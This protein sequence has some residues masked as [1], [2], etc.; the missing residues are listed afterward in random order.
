MR[1]ASREEFAEAYTQYPLPREVY[2]KRARL[3]E[4]FPE[5][6]LIVGCGFGLLV[7]ELRNLGKDARGIDA[8]AWAWENRDNE[9]VWCSDIL[10]ASKVDIL[11]QQHGPFATIITE[12]LLPW[13]TEEEVEMCARNCTGLG[14][15]VIHM[16]TEQGEAP[17]NYH[18]CVYWMALTKQLTCSLGGF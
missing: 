12:D 7:S 6:I 8:S 15:I 14:K 5:K 17:Y 10:N 1:L 11:R 16:V 4:G 2:A 13:L 9:W 18:P 3:F